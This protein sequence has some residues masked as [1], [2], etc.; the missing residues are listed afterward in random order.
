MSHAQNYLLF[1]RYK[2]NVFNYTSRSEH[3]GSTHQSDESL[4]SG[5]QEVPEKTALDDTQPTQTNSAK[6][7]LLRLFESK[8]FDMSM[9]ITYLF[10]SKE[11]GVQSYIGMININFYFILLKLY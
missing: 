5:P 10:N 2:I 4:D 1:D 8:L 7:F 6:G 11:P 9:A 3:T